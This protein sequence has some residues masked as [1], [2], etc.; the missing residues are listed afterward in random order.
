MVKHTR[1]KKHAKS[2]SKKHHGAKPVKKSATKKRKVNGFMSAQMKAKKNNAP[3]FV[4][5]GNTYKKHTKGHLVYY[6]KV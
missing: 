6:K 2:S 5:K 1:S 3:S 4:Y